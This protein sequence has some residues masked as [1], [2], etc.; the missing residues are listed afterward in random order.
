MI[1]QNTV[2][3]G[4]KTAII[5]YIT[6]FGTIS[7]MVM[8]GEKKNAFAAFH[9]RQSLGIFISFFLLGYFVGYFDNWMATYSFWT[10]IFVLWIYGFLTALQGQMTAIPL[11]GAFF[12]KIFK[13]IE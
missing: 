8:N 4:K 13:N 5:S 7:A 12:Q 10:F 2:E 9:I 11:L 1:T 6:I 3:E